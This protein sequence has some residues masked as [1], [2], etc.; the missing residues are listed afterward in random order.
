MTS[1]AR[2]FVKRKLHK[3]CGV[4]EACKKA[5]GFFDTLKKTPVRGREFFFTQK[6]PLPQATGVNI[7][8]L[9]SRYGLEAGLLLALLA[10]EI[11]GLLHIRQHVVAH[12]LR[13]HEEIGAEGI[14]NGVAIVVNEHLEVIHGL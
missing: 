8:V 3:K 2:F 5:I 1:E 14:N 12:E 9:C 10:V 13:P 4:F 7:I 6:R 11:L